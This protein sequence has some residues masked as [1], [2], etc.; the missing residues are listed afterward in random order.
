MLTLF[1][2]AFNLLLLLRQLALLSNPR[3]SI[4]QSFFHQKRARGISG[5]KEETRASAQRM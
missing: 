1:A 5:N 2:D 3:K 4:E